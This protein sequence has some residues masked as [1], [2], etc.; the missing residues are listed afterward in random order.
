MLR[1]LAAGITSNLKTLHGIHPFESAPAAAE[2]GL[3]ASSSG[4]MRLWSA[5]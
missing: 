5:L 2:T 4:P 1:R 3:A